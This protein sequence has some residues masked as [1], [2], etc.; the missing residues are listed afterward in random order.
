MPDRDDKSPPHALLENT[1]SALVLKVGAFLH[2]TAQEIEALDSLET[3]EFSLAKDQDLAI[4]GDDI[5]STF[6]VVEG[7]LGR[8]RM[9]EDGRR[10]IISFALP[11]DILNLDG[12]LVTDYVYSVMALTDAVVC[13]VAAEAVIA[14]TQEH[15]RLGAAI[16]WM[17][18]RE[19][20]LLAEQ[21]VRVGRRSAYERVAHLILELLHRLHLVHEAEKRSY[22]LPLTQEVL[23][24]ALGLSL[25]HVNRTLRRLRKEGLI[26]MD[27]NSLSIDDVDRLAE[28]AEFDPAYLRHDHIPDAAEQ[29]INDPV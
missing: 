26:R 27:G 6:V 13:A 11:G 8:Y 9:L 23:G 12:A 7:W 28:V 20:T 2:L 18:A 5:R 19:R 21:V 29:A 4:E 16:S 3:R 24:D 25:V 22:D 15:P 10:Q 1:P 14:V 17:G